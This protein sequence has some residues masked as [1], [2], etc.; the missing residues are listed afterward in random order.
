MREICT[1]G[2]TRGEEVAPLRRPLSYSTGSVC[3]GW[4][5]QVGAPSA[6]VSVGTG[7][8]RGFGMRRDGWDRRAVP[9]AAVSVGTGGRAERLGERWDR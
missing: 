5:G 4:L 9:S 6:A 3:A 2:S 1:S 8:R 7:G